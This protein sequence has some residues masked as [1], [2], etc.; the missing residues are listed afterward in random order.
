[1]GSPISQQ[2]V[3]L[4]VDTKVRVRLTLKRDLSELRRCGT[5]NDVF[6]QGFVFSHPFLLLLLV[7]HLPIDPLL[8][9]SSLCFLLG[10]FLFSVRVRLSSFTSAC[11]FGAIVRYLSE[12]R[13]G[14][15]KRK[16]ERTFRGTRPISVNQF[17]SMP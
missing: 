13:R 2:Q 5:C 14:K 4:V 12:E 16:K 6:P 3:V 8:L 1:M 17:Y 15:K 9:F 10:P 11:V 7:L